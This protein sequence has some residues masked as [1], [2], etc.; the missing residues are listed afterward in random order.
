LD[1]SITTSTTL[2]HASAV[3]SILLHHICIQ[4]ILLEIETGYLDV[5]QEL[6]SL[7]AQYFMQLEV[8][9]FG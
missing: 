3:L 9:L 1:Y 7:L 8:F 5:L 2:S 4:F 6:H